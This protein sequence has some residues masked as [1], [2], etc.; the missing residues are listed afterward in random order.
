MR[1][2]GKLTLIIS[3]ALIA[4]LWPGGPVV[5]GEA[6]VGEGQAPIG[7]TREHLGVTLELP[8]IKI[9]E[10][11]TS[12]ATI[13]QA[14][15]EQE[16]AEIVSARNRYH[17]W[18]RAEG[19]L[20]D[21]YDDKFYQWLEDEGYKP[22]PWFDIGYYWREGTYYSYGDLSGLFSATPEGQAR[23][24]A[25][26]D[27]KRRADEAWSYLMMVE[28]RAE[29]ATAAEEGYEELDKFGRALGEA[30]EESDTEAVD[31][32]IDSVIDYLQ[33]IVVP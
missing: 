9:I 3:A 22:A 2:F 30:L 5:G 23:V 11:G 28:L 13:K 6:A 18:L 8:T 32:D 27:A 4:G 7:D 14:V 29:R 15:P 20:Q 31:S 17:Q 19:M 33:P 10:E 21:W 12:G 24:A 25:W 1:T 26:E 16:P